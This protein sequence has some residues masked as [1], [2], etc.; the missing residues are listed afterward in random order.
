MMLS[1]SNVSAAQA[2]NYYESDDYYTAGLADD[3]SPVK[4]GNVQV[5]VARSSDSKGRS[6]ALTGD[7]GQQSVKVDQSSPKI[8]LNLPAQWQGKGAIALGLSGSVEPAHF[9]T[10]LHGQDLQGHNLHAKAINLDTHRAATDYTFSAPKSVSIAALIQRDDRV[11]MAH[12]RAVAVALAVLEDRYTQARIST[13][14]GRQKVTT[15]NLIAAVFRHET[16]RDQDPQLHSHC[17]T[18]NTTQLPD[19][20]WRSMSNEAVIAQQKLLGQIYQNELAYQL[21]QYGYGIDPRPNG[22][23]ELTGYSQAV[24]DRYSTRSHA[25]AAYLEHRAQATGEPVT[26]ADRKQ[27][28]LKTRKNKAKGIPREV[29][30]QSWQADLEAQ[31][32]TLPPI[33]NSELNGLLIRDGAVN[34]CVNEDVNHVVN[35]SVNHCSERDTLFSRSQMERFALEHHLGEQSFTDLNAAFA[36]N[37]ELIKVDLQKDRYTTQTAIDRELETL[38]LMR[39]GQGQVGEIAALAEVTQLTQHLTLT[40]GQRQA[41]EFSA[42]TTDRVIGWQ[43]VA[44]AGK[45]Y[46]LYRLG[47]LA[48]SKGYTVRGFAPSAEAANVLGREAEIPSD[49]VASWLNAKPNPAALLEKELWIVDE[50]G[51]LSAKDAQ[52]LLQKAAQQQARVILVGDTRQLSAV[53]AGNPFQSLQAGG[54]ATVRLDESLRQRTASLKAAVALVANGHIE[55]GLDALKQAGCLQEIPDPAQRL[56]QIAQDYLSLSAAQQAETLVIAGTH[57]ERLELVQAIRAGLQAR[58]LLGQNV[59]TIQGLR[60][61]DLT[62]AQAQ[63]IWHYEIGDVVQPQR[64]YPQLG[65]QKHQ[66]YTVL[67]RDPETN[68][69]WLQA[70]FG[71]HLTINP[72]HCEQKTVYQVQEIPIAVGDRLRWTQNNRAAGIRNGQ[73]FTLQQLD[74]QGHAQIRYDDGQIAAIT[75]SGQQP[76]DYA[77]MSTTYSAQGKTAE[78]V[79]VATEAMNSRES[80]YVA[81]SRAKTHLTLYTANTAELTRRAQISRANATVLP[82]YQQVCYAQTPQTSASARPDSLHSGDAI[83]RLRDRLAAALPEDWPLRAGIE[84]LHRG[85]SPNPRTVESIA[86]TVAAISLRRRQATVLEPLAKPDPEWQRQAERLLQGAQLLLQVSGRTDPDG[87]RRVKGHNYGLEQEGQTLTLYRWS[88]GPSRKEEI[89]TYK[90]QTREWVTEL[91]GEEMRAIGD[92]LHQGVQISQHRRE[93]EMKRSRSRDRGMEA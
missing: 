77:W 44:G 68:R 80:F 66:R 91:S 15:A 41:L 51:L 74:P 56:Q 18:I 21:R 4:V 92:V 86:R 72:A 73:I 76:I 79:L 64:H 90:G 54:M 45:T 33:P 83:R 36:A 14:T 57:Q 7:L 26:A 8:D 11:L 49:T 58:D 30:L 31:G 59:C 13:P 23:F 24:L 27:A 1:M 37:R 63:Y 38:R 61:K 9:R 82:L 60:P 46:S 89:L 16:S 65:L 10:L 34:S 78:R 3:E 20:S 22:Q 35:S 42:T 52:A 67:G 40:E 81:V 84:R 2:E 53:E 70:E 88:L 39:Q 47:E 25:I 69:L 32:L 93:E 48:A 85:A 55:S 62:T 12:D 87:R 28:T 5:K 29:L 50:A 43:G 19:G 6:T 17:V 71:Q 75:L